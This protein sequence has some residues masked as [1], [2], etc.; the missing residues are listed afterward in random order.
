MT[1]APGETHESG[2]GQA[3]EAWVSSPVQADERGQVRGGE[4]GQRERGATPPSALAHEIT[5][6]LL[7]QA[8]EL[9]GE[10]LVRVRQSSALEK[11]DLEMILEGAHGQQVA[12]V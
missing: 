11:V 5:E 9:A 3:R 7:T 1:T 12:I 10:R 2:T 6:I 4:E 8:P